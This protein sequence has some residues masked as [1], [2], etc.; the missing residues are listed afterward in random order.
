VHL[1]QLHLKSFSTHKFQA[2]EM[3]KRAASVK[4]PEAMYFYGKM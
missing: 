4:H 1:P 3:L 2:L